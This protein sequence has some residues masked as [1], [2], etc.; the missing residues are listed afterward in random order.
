MTDISKLLADEAAASEAAATVE[1]PMVRN[2]V[3]AK[4]P[5]QVYSLRIPLGRLQELRERA[6]QQHVAPTVLMRRWVL[7][8]LDEEAERG[9]RLEERRA[10]LQDER[11]EEDLL[12]L[13]Q[14]ELTTLVTSVLG[15]LV[16]AAQ[17]RPVKDED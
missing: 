8:R 17:G 12:V 2:R 10:A 14:A 3:K 7:D 4:E 15:K 1:T 11:G 16:A 13:T 9:S 5:S 6:E